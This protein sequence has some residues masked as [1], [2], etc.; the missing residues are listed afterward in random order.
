MSNIHVLET[1]SMNRHTVGLT[2]LAKSKQLT[3]TSGP[4]QGRRNHF[5]LL[6]AQKP[7]DHQPRVASLPRSSKLRLGHREKPW[8]VQKESER[9]K[10][11]LK[12]HIPLPL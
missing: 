10:D 9:P 4:A 3:V 2:H 1:P 5:C 8:R 12:R 7:P 11:H 6:R